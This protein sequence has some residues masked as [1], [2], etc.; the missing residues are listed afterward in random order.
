PASH[1]RVR[2][3]RGE[4]IA[5]PITFDAD[6]ARAVLVELPELT[7]TLWRLGA[8]AVSSPSTCAAE[9]ATQLFVHAG[10][11]WLDL[12][13]ADEADFADNDAIAFARGDTLMCAPGSTWR[14]RAAPGSEAILAEHTVRWGPAV[15]NSDA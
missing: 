14:L 12:R 7:A 11:G 10:A 8:A 9:Y 2:I 1:Q 13:G 4:R 3:E 6:A 15:T 5:S